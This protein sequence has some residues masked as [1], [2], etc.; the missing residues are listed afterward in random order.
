MIEKIY[1]FGTSFTAGGGWEW[2]SEMPYKSQRLPALYGHI[3]LPKTQFDFSWPGR[4]QKLL[5]D[6]NQEIEVINLAKCGY[7]NERLYRKVFELV[8]DN[9]FQ[10]NKSLLL[11]EFSFMMRKEFYFRPLN[12]YIICNYHFVRD[13]KNELKL[14]GPEM[15]HSWAYDSP[16]TQNLLNSYSQLFNEFFSLTM[17]EEDIIKKINQGITLILSFLDNANIN[18][19]TTSTPTINPDLYRFTNYD[20]DR[21][22]FWEKDGKITEELEYFIT[23]NKLDFTHETKGGYNDFHAGY[24]GCREIA[25][26]AFNA[27]IDK[28]Y[29]KGEKLKPDWS[30]I[31]YSQPII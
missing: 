26:Q 14:N 4:L 16:E 5:K 13:K 21:K 25:K 12:D 27:L 23:N 2:D 22:I 10:K 28:N 15:A 24:Q 29:I 31:N 1:T 6:S 9:N 30:W 8:T 19:L 11:L 20:E 18:Y 17:D 3:D 7:G